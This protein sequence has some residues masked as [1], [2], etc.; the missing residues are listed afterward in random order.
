M[1][2]LA[3]R[4]FSKQVKIQAGLSKLEARTTNSV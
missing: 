3:S 2:K 4:Q 1:D